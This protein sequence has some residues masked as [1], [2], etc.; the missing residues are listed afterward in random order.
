[1]RI[2]SE[3]FVAALIRR[4]FAAGD[5]AAIER[6]GAAEAGAIFIRQRLR[7]GLETVYG[8]APQAL[9]DAAAMTDGRQFETRLR[10]S[11]AQEA[12]DLIDREHRFDADLWVVEIET[13]SVNGLLSLVDP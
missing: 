10:A 8:P 5:F 13:D 3:F 12:A 7:N 2:T 9:S 6:K 1:M 4:V 11:E